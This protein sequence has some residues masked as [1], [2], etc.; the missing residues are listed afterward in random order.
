[1]LF[2]IGAPVM[3]P[4]AM[5]LCGPILLGNIFWNCLYPSNFCKKFWLVIL[6]II[7]G[8]MAD[9]LVWIGSIFYFIPLGINKLYHWYK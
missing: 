8:L 7:I 6:S 3:I 4:V 9:P 5:I 1:M 2:I